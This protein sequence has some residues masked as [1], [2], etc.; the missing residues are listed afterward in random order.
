MQDVI[1]ELLHGFGVLS[2]KGLKRK[3]DIAFVL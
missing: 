3:T 1:Q 2:I